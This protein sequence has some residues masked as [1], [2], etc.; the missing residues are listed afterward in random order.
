M[1]ALIVMLKHV[2][3]SEENGTILDP[4]VLCNLALRYHGIHSRP[5]PTSQIRII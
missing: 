4:F 1:C 5:P 3:S 2:A